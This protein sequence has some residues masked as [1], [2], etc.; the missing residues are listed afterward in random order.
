MVEHEIPAFALY[1]TGS[2]CCQSSPPET[3]LACICCGLFFTFTYTWKMLLLG[4]GCCN[5]RWH[6]YIF[7]GRAQ[8]IHRRKQNNNW[9]W[10]SSN[11]EMEKAFTIWNLYAPIC[12]RFLLPGLEVY[13]WIRTCQDFWN[14]FRRYDTCGSSCGK[15]DFKYNIRGSYKI[16]DSNE[17]AQ[18]QIC[19]IWEICCR[20]IKGYQTIISTCF[21]IKAK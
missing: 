19:L 20:I 16:V 13:L 5:F 12:V 4:L 21:T 9:N 17:R 2:I 6:D 1:F 15:N 7:A 14:K 11:T 18:I 10:R 8:D 3:K